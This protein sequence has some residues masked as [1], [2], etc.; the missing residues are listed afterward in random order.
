[1]QFDTYTVAGA[2]IACWMAN[3]T[4]GDPAALSAVLASYDVHEPIVTWRQIRAL[5]PWAG[6]LRTVFEAA[7]EAERA[8]RADALLVAADCRPRLVRHTD[9]RPFHLHYAPVRAGLAARVRA[10]TAGG[11]AHV[12]DDGSGFRLRVCQRDGCESAFVDVSRNGRRRF[13]SLRCANQVN[14]ANHRRRQRRAALLLILNV[15]VELHKAITAGLVV[16]FHERES[17]RRVRGP[18]RGPAWRPCASGAW[19]PWPPG[20]SSCSWRRCRCS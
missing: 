8:Q 4:A 13:C 2:H 1:M 15:M 9:D 6:C 18:V 19:R 17:R 20:P 10:L 16:W 7:T 14:V 5:Q 12:I 3:N 11:L